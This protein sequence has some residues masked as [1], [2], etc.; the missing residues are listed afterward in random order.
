MIYIHKYPRF[1]YARVF[2]LS[3]CIVSF[4][5][6]LFCLRSHFGQTAVFAPFIRGVFSEYSI[7]TFQ[8]LCVYYFMCVTVFL[9]FVF[10][11]SP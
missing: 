8:I 9:L 7:L 2:S 1:V 3:L 11:I 6:P 10:L 4:F 5:V